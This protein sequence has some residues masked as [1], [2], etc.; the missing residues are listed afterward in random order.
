MTE[1]HTNLGNLGARTTDLERQLLIQTTEAEVLNRR[2]QE[3]ENPSG[4]QGRVLAERD[5]RMRRN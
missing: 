1:A 5:Y 3:L 4:D 2:V